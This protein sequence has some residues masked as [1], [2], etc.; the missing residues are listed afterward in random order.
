MPTSHLAEVECFDTQ[1][2]RYNRVHKC[3]YN[4]TDEILDNLYKPRG[5]CTISCIVFSL[6][7]PLFFHLFIAYFLLS[8]I[9]VILELVSQPVISVPRSLYSAILGSVSLRI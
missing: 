8:R 9:V 7:M 1:R 3:V 6:L 5:E 2:S 4:A